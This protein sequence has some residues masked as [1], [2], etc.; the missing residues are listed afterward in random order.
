M[1]YFCWELRFPQR[2]L[3]VPYWKKHGD[4]DRMVTRL[5][6]IDSHQALTLLKNC[7][8]IP[9]LQYILRATEAYK[10]RPELE[11]FDTTVRAAVAGIVNVGFSTESWKQATLLVAYGGLGIRSA[12]DIAL[13]AFLSSLHSVGNLVNTV[14]SAVPGVVVANNLTDAEEAWSAEHEG[15]VPPEERERPRQK[16]WDMTSATQRLEDMLREGD[17][18]TRARLLAASRKE[19][20]LWLHAIPVPSLG[21]QLDPETLRVA[22]ALRV[23]ADVPHTWQRMDS[24]G[25]HGLSCRY[26][27]GLFA[28]P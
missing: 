28:R 15:V 6:L 8:A 20:G 11:E 5:Q 16:S 23:G 13:P 3:L 2:M 17:Q 24:K 10:C 4:L 7:F 26:S 18:V 1:N 27:A 12:R 14:L 25:L 19:S 9:K 21:T 22:V